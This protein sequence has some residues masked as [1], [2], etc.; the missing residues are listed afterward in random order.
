[1]T[2]ESTSSGAYPIPCQRLSLAR[3]CRKLEG[4]GASTHQQ[5]TRARC[6]LTESSKSFELPLHCL[7]NPRRKD[8]SELRLRKH[9][10]FIFCPLQITRFMFVCS[11]RFPEQGSRG[12][13]LLLEPGEATPQVFCQSH[14]L[15]K[16]GF[17]ALIV[18]D[19]RYQWYNMNPSDNR[20]VSYL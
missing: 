8:S 1:M 13:A 4:P 9:R 14:V 7:S 12:T 10:L 17:N 18:V 16:N 3:S 5:G 15:E 2:T 11:S 20:H 19:R 6:A